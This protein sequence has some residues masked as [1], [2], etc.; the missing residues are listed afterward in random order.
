MVERGRFAPT[1]SGALHL[2]SARTALAGAL[3]IRA[4]GGRFVLRVEDLDGTRTKPGA[5]RAMLE[6]L[7]WLG[8]RFD[9]GPA[10]GPHAPYFQ[11]QRAG[12][13]REALAVLQRAGRVYPCACSRKEI[14]ELAAAPHGSE[15]VYP[16]TCRDRDPDEVLAFAKAR[17]RAAAWRFRVEPGLVRVEDEVA[18]GFEQD[19]SRDVGDFVVFRADGLAAYQLAV[20]VDDVAMEVPHVLRGDDLLA[21]APRQQTLYRA[22]GARVPAW[23][24]LPLV[25]NDS[26]TRLAKRD[27]ALSIADL[28]ALGIAADALRDALLDSLCAGPSRAEWN[29]DRIARGPVSLGALCELLPPLRA[30]LTPGTAG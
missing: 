24:H 21:S 16:G 1:P 11:S 27:G 7:R 6:D 4:R 23:A 10:G 17:G 25:V 19:L 29:P 22:F 14:D 13:Y 8:V 20:V 9:E 26:G 18:G 2:G 3:A 12:L 30:S 5:V 15:P 28:R